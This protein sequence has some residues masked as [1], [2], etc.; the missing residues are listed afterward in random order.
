MI[1]PPVNLRQHCNVEYLNPVLSRCAPRSPSH[2]YFI[3]GDENEI[4][5]S[6][7]AYNMDNLQDILIN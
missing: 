6:H 1:G 3:I 4:I 2:C 5:W 7:L